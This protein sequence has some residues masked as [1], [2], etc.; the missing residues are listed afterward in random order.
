MFELGQ[1]WKIAALTIN[2]MCTFSFKQKNRSEKMFV[3]MKLGKYQK[4]KEE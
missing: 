3:S 1:D 4:I 2:I